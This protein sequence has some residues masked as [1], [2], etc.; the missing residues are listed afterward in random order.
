MNLPELSTLT[1]EA[2]REMTRTQRAALPPGPDAKAEDLHIPGPGGP[3]PARLYRPHDANGALPV[4][5]WFHGGGFVIGSMAES[6]PDARRLA[7]S[8]GIAVVSVDYRLAP[9]HP[10]PAGLHDCYAA[11]KWVAENA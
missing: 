8:A 2:G 5:V 1:P 6:D 10:F 11:T 4:L 7:T 3:V 9:E